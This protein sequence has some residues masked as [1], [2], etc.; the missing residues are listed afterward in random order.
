VH[1]RRVTASRTFM[2]NSVTLST[3]LKTVLM[4]VR[5]PASP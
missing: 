5:P 4:I 1:P 2:P 3:T